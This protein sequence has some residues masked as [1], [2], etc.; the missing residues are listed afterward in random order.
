MSGMLLVVALLLF[1]LMWIGHA[2]LWTALLN[3]V[4]GHPLPKFL[5]KAWRY[6]TGLTIAA[7]PLLLG[8]GLRD[9]ALEVYPF[10]EELG[11]LATRAYAAV[12]LVVGG[13]VFPV[14]TIARRCAAPPDC[15][16][17][18]TT[19]TLDL[20]PD[21]GA[22]LIGDGKLAL[23]TRLPA[24]CVFRIDFTDLTLTLRGLP[25]EWEGLTI[26]VA[27]DFHFHGTPSRLFFERVIDEIAAD[28]MPDVLC[29]LGDFVDTERHHEWVSPLLGRLSA[30][31]GKFAI[32]GNHDLHYDPAH[33]R[34]E[35]AASGY[36]VLGNGWVDATIRGVPCVVIGHEGP[37]FRPPPDLS[38]A[39]GH[40]RLCLSHTPDNFYWG[41]ANRIQ[42]ML[43][44]HVH[45]G[46]I[47]LPVVGSIFVPSK[48]G[49]RFDQ[50]VFEQDGTTMAV[51]RGLSGREPIRFRCN[52]QVLRVRLVGRGDSLT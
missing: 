16:V 44:G 11:A 17:S 27:N 5:L 31:D 24:N 1:A 25:S 8:G 4:Y 12:C 29:L 30:R 6:L 45:G 26:L 51:N 2:C 13:L 33:L 50:G 22:K 34:R 9:D 46:A 43:S 20:W 21:Y 7:F 15:V 36:T 10:P 35:L 39:P 49:R 18:Q 37:W 28:P 48:Y 41:V 40:F 19:R 14:I 38:G 23:A 42:L 32:L 52:P 3:R 47:R